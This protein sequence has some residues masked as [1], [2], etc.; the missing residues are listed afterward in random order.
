MF[1]HLQNTNE[2]IFML[3]EGFLSFQNVHK[4]IVKTYPYELSGSV[5]I[6]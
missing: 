5:Q 2:D 6:F 1:L 3:P 4:E